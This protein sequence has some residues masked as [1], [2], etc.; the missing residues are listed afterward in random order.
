MRTTLV[1]QTGIVRVWVGLERY[2]H[3]CQRC[4]KIVGMIPAELL[5]IWFQRKGGC[6]LSLRRSVAVFLY[7]GGCLWNL[8]CELT[9]EVAF[10]GQ[11][12]QWLHLH[13]VKLCKSLEVIL[14]ITR[15]LVR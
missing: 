3:S 7:L 10:L 15:R 2:D 4:A 1:H 6:C 14:S 12:A 5:K 8:W 9:D 11:F 13:L